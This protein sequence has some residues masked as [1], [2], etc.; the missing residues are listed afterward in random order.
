[1]RTFSFFVLAFRAI[2]VLLL[3][4]FFLPAPRGHPI[5][6]FI[7][8]FIHAGLNVCVA[9]ECLF[10]VWLKRS[11]FWEKT[12]TPT[13][14]L[15]DHNSEKFVF[16][17]SKRGLNLTN[18]KEQAPYI[19]KHLFFLTMSRIPADP[20]ASRPQNGMHPGGPALEDDPA[21]LQLIA[22][23][24]PQPPSRQIVAWEGPRQQPV[25]GREEVDA[26]RPHNGMHPGGPALEDDPAPLQLMALR[27]PQP[28]SRQIVPWEG[29]R[30][31]PV[32]GR[33]EVDERRAVMF[34]PPPRLDVDERRAVMFLPP[35]RLDDVI[36]EVDL[37]GAPRVDVGIDEVDLV[38]PL[39]RPPRVHP[40]R[41]VPRR[42]NDD[43]LMQRQRRPIHHAVVVP[44]PAHLRV[45]DAP[46]EPVNDRTGANELL[47]IF[48]RMKE[49]RTFR[50]NRPP[51][52]D[53]LIAM[54]KAIIARERSLYQGRGRP[55]MATT[56]RRITSFLRS[57]C[58]MHRF[59]AAER[60]EIRRN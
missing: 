53:E 47:R 56:E 20:H 32:I 4:P 45:H 59:S 30:Q 29:P 11:K 35:P 12:T 51:S 18:F 52:R 57:V 41:L 44:P 28:P 19:C 58:H 50:N 10:T 1:M 46:A 25:I 26:S 31:Q 48:S 17:L 23:R 60:L 15:T 37:F 3:N 43:R 54:V 38:R 6:L 33:E 7:Y 14:F 36:D 42:G 21:P 34:L 16:G 40:I 49:I 8:L 2:A 55:A 24:E 22:F 13:F 39:V 27:E 9:V 5:F